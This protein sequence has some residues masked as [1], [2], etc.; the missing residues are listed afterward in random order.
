MILTSIVYSHVEFRIVDA[1][2][3]LFC[4][5]RFIIGTVMVT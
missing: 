5:M 2:S 1:F 3:I 4:L